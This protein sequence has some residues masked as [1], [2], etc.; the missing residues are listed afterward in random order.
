MP[1]PSVRGRN[2]KVDVAGLD[3]LTGLHEVNSL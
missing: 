1:P 2:I 3:I